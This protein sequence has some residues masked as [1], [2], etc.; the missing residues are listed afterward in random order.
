M[1]F[2]GRYLLLILA[3]FVIGLIVFV[4]FPMQR[5]LPVW[6]NESSIGYASYKFSTHKDWEPDKQYDYVVLRRKLSAD[7]PPSNFNIQV[8]HLSEV[9]AEKEIGLDEYVNI[10]LIQELKDVHKSEILSV[11]DFSIDKFPAKD[12][13][14]QNSL[15]IREITREIKSRIIVFIAGEYVYS[16]TLGSFE[17]DFETA[18]KEF[19]LMVKSFHFTSK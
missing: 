6:H 15:T 13:V 2:P 3:A 16:F 18:S 19:E 4:F 8:Q 17:K 10:H 7:L 1:R 14:Y 9:I 11:K 5:Q 12:I